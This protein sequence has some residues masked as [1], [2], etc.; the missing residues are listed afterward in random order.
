MCSEIYFKEK[1]K[2]ECDHLTIILVVEKIRYVNKK[3]TQEK[4]KSCSK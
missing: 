1:N 2:K 3:V 4:C